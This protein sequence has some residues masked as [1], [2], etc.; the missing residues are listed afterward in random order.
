MLTIALLALCAEAATTVSSELGGTSSDNEGTLD[1]KLNRVTVDAAAT[2]ERIEVWA[3]TGGWN[4]ADVTYVVYELRSGTTWD[5]R[6]EGGGVINGTVGWQASPDVDLELLPGRTYAVGMYLGWDSV[7]YY[8]ANNSFQSLSWGDHLGG[9]YTGNGSLWSRPD[10]FDEGN[11]T[12]GYRQR[13]TL[14]VPDDLDND[15][16]PEGVDCDE[17][18][19]A[20]NPG[21]V[22]SCDG[23]DENC[24]G[25]I[26]D[27]VGYADWWPDDDGD[28]FGAVRSNPV[29]TCD[30]APPGHVDNYDD[31][32]DTDPTTA[33]GAPETCDGQD[34]DC[35]GVP[36]DGVVYTDWWPDDDGDGFGAADA[37]P[38]NTC[39][40]APPGH[41][42]DRTDCDDLRDDAFPGAPERCNEL[43]DDCDGTLDEELVY[44]DWWPDADGDGFGDEDAEP[45]SDCVQRDGFTEAAD[46]CDDS[47]PDVSPDATE[48]C[49]GLDDDCTGFPRRDE[50]DLD[51]DGALACDDCND[52]D[53]TVFPGAVDDCNGVDND[54]DGVIPTAT[55]CDPYLNESVKVGAG[56]GCQTSRSPAPA[57]GLLLL[58]GLRRRSRRPTTL[59]R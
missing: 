58:L 42:D 55:D 53:A 59:A 16:W 17:S 26:D 40:G 43:D 32:D 45:T 6:W 25:V 14:T 29:N 36:D 35:D 30:G 41:V 4:D 2:L 5:L 13:L 38:V 56:C 46:D 3:V 24:D 20:I 34:D 21:V 28:G 31:C 57:F 54:C 27:D 9:L 22:E 49:N 50:V 52:G 48:Q 33:P 23:T 47:N 7:Q 44:T 12:L 39:D 37:S 18:N 8:W 11:A 1:V 51:G 10:S 19:P 15:G